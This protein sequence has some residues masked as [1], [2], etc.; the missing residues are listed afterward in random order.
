[1]MPHLLA[2]LPLPSLDYADRVSIGKT[3]IAESFE[4]KSARR[5]DA[6]ATPPY[7]PAKLS[8]SRKTGATWA[9]SG[10][11]SAILPGFPATIAGLEPI[12]VFIAQAAKRPPSS[13]LSG[14]NRGANGFRPPTSAVQWTPCTLVFTLFKISLSGEDAAVA[15]L[16]GAD[17]ERTVAHVHVFT[18][19]PQG[20]VT[21]SP[22]RRS[23]SLVGSQHESR[24]QR[25]EVERRTLSRD[26]T[27][28]ICKSYTDADGR[29]VVLSIYFGNED[30]TKAGNEWILEL[31]DDR[32]LHE[33]I[34][35]IK[36]TAIMIK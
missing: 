19:K 17:E 16:N 2:P 20:V 11:S 6:S 26:S 8:L 34:C 33:W 23:K 24:V 14:T 9:P 3:S 12:T 21:G 10:I 22:M 13:I 18:S 28:S 5:M 36:K 29:A 25:V 4:Y 1:M 7:T 15:S 31:K 27:A 30:R 32:Q 35:Q